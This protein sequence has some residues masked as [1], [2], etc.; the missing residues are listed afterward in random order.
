MTSAITGTASTT[1]AQQ[2]GST[3]ASNPNATLD[4]D[5]FLKMFVAQMQNQDPS[6]SQDPNEST[7][8]MATFSMVEQITNL[9]SQ[10]Q[11]V[12][13]A[14]GTS[15]AVG[16]IGH[17]VTYTDTTGASQTG[18]VQKVATN[19]SGASTLTVAGQS[20]VAP[21]SITEVA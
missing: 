11:K 13:S 15:S 14:L 17:T 7:Q 16:L 21:T 4:K 10:E 12:V 2:S 5:G 8:Q 6:N 19:A 9:V 20:G 3:S 18:V 1:S